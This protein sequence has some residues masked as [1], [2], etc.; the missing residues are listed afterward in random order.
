MYYARQGV[1]TLT[2]KKRFKRRKKEGIREKFAK[3]LEALCFSTIFLVFLF[4]LG[5][6]IY[7]HYK[8]FELRKERDR[9]LKENFS[10]QRRFEKMTS[11]ERII[12]KAKEL[13][14][15]L[16]KKEDYLNPSF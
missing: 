12:K 2:S 10:L 5:F 13:N 4:L 15:V 8:L 14:L 11:R 1:L 6:L 7:Q 3:F 16:P 9:L